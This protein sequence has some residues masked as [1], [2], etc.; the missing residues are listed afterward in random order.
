MA[1]TVHP[2]MRDL[3]EEV[4]FRERGGQHR[5][6]ITDELDPERHRV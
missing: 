3:A 5:Y 6:R 2:F 1:N 4:E